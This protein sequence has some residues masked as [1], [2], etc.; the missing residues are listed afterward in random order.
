MLVYGQALVRPPLPCLF[1]ISGLIHVFQDQSAS[2]ERAPF[3]LINKVQA[4]LLNG[5]RDFS[6]ASCQRSGNR[7]SAF[8]AVYRGQWFHAS[9]CLWNNG[10]G[11]RAKCTRKQPI[12]PFRREV[13]QIASDDQIPDR[14]RGRQSGGNSSQRPAVGCV[15]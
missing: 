13:W 7:C 6:L 14:V 2:I 3:A 8:A 11:A 12:K 15:P 5:V 1:V 4:K 9:L 10:L